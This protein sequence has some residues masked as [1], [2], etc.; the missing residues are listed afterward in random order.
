MFACDVTGE[1]PTNDFLDIR[2]ERKVLAIGRLR[3]VKF[4]ADDDDEIEYEVAA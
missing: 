2:R 3:D 1:P 4:L